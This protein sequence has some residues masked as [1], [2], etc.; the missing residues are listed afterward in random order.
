MTVINIVVND[1]AAQKFMLMSSKEKESV[2]QLV[3]EIIVDARTLEQV[4]ED[5]TMYAK[6]RGLTPEK[7]D[8]ILNED[9][10]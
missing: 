8:E 7:F 9:N 10:E 1:K 6:K 3:N 2:S 5:M 4:M